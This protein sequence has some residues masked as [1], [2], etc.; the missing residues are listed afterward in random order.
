MALTDAQKAKMLKLAQLAKFKELQDAANDA[1]FIPLSQKGVANGVATL[2][3]VGLIPASQ[4]P[5]YVD[6]IIE[7]AGVS[8][9]LPQTSEGY[10]VG[11]LFYAE[12]TETQLIYTAIEDNKWS[13][14]GTTP[15]GGKI[16]VDVSTKKLYRWAG[17]TMVE[18]SA[19]TNTTYKI[20]INGNEVGGGVNS[21][22]TVYA[23]TVAGTAGKIVKWVNG[24]PAWADPD[25]L[26]FIAD[27]TVSEL[28]ASALTEGTLTK[29]AAFDA[30]VNTENTTPMQGKVMLIPNGTEGYVIADISH[31]AG[32]TLDFSFLYDGTYYHVN[33]DTATPRNYTV[34]K[35][36][37]NAIPKTQLASAV[38]ASLGKADTAVQPGDLVY[39]DDTDIAALF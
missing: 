1:K 15:E 28:I 21:L 17:S 13:P 8:N 2:N 29:L 9:E 12:G 14:G 35:L 27:F 24:A 3:G 23:P 11:A 6:D 31:L 39:A 10:A 30:L 19:D 38:Q 34:T 26:Y 16:Y 20:N 32:S 33:G 5:S 22:G 25:V 36:V 7:L 4:L 37:L 18:V